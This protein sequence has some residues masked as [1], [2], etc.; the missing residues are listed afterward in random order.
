MTLPVARS[1]CRIVWVLLLVG[2]GGSS[3]GYQRANVDSLEGEELLVLGKV[4]VVYDDG[5][6]TSS[7]GIRT[8]AGRPV[9]YFLDTTGLVSWV[10][11]S[12]PEGHRMDFL[13]LQGE[14]GG[15]LE[16]GEHAPV[17]VPSGNDE[18][19][20]YFGTVVVLLGEADASRFP[21]VVFERR[22]AAIRVGVEDEADTV[23]PRLASE[24]DSLRGQQYFHVLRNAVAG[25]P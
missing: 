4:R 10:T 19:I 2:C 6:V 1:A 21:T 13:H 17:L 3:T 12:R 9:D 22:S 14:R 25:V 20:V 16:L 15:D 7:S 11:R 5:D 23:V 18:R 24:N 8:R